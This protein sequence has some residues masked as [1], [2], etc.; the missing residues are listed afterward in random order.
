MTAQIAQFEKHY[1]HKTHKNTL[2]AIYT[3]CS[4]LKLYGLLRCTSYGRTSFIAV[5]N[6]GGQNAT[7]A[8]YSNFCWG[9]QV[10][11]LGGVGTPQPSLANRALNL[12]EMAWWRRM[13]R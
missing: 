3:D 6:C 8:C 1:E 4:Y 13:N 2:S 5:V 10:S 11:V 9:S 7:P 12:K